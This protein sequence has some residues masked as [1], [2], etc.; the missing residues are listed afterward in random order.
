MACQGPS[1]ATY[2]EHCYMTSRVLDVLYDEFGLYSSDVQINS[3]T[4]LY[5]P[6]TDL[7]EAVAILKHGIAK[8]AEIKANVEF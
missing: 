4:K 6:A 3:L 5:D 2:E 7:A 8:L 1:Y